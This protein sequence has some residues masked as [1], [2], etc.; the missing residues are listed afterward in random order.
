MCNMQHQWFRTKIDSMI[1][2]ISIST[3]PSEKAQAFSDLAQNLES[4]ADAYKLLIKG[5]CED[6]LDTKL[7]LACALEAASVALHSVGLSHTRARS[8]T[9]AAQ[10]H[11]KCATLEQERAKIYGALGDREMERAKICGALGDREMERAGALKDAASALSS[12]LR[13]HARA[14]NHAGVTKAREKSAA[15]LREA[16]DIIRNAR[17]GTQCCGKRARGCSIQTTHPQQRPMKNTLL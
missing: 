12:A 4:L 15:L 8:H 11:E 14:G 9:D 2:K 1:R 17:T 3:D 13:S 5:S 7:K 6:P 10:A 16:A